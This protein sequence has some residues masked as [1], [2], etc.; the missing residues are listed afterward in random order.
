MD[1]K[2]MKKEDKE[3]LFATVKKEMNI[4]PELRQ[5][6]LDN[7][8][9]TDDHGMHIV[10]MSKDQNGKE[11]YIVK[12]SWG[13]DNDYKGFLY[14]SKAYVQYKTTSI[15]LNKKGVPASIMQKVQP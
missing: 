11:Y 9:T 2:R 3:A 5:Q 1:A 13:E 15:L 6:G 8:A 7:Q 4:T 12:N 14:V 10:G